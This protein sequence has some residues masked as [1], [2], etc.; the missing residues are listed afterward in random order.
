MLQRCSFAFV[1]LYCSSNNYL[2]LHCLSGRLAAVLAAAHLS[3]VAGVAA[4]AAVAA[5]RREHG[6]PTFSARLKRDCWKQV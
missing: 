6:G 5:S 1:D 4:V 3:A 2:N